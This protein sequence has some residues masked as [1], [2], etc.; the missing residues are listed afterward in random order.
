MVR[1][2]AVEGG[3]TTW[4]AAICENEAS[5]VVAKQ[6]FK[7]QSPSDTLESIR[8]WL[9]TQCFDC[10]GVATFGPVDANRKSPK[11]GFITSTP[12]PGAQ[13]STEF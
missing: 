11:Y 12:K 8:S 2:A 7:T 4:V 5:N 9:N 13:S 10:I 3:G 6:E 1:I